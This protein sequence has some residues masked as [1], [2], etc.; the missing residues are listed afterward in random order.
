MVIVTDDSHDA[1]NLELFL[2]LNMNCSIALSRTVTQTLELLSDD[3]VKIIIA[4]VKGSKKEA[5]RLIEKLNAGS[6]FV[7][8][9]FYTACQNPQRFLE[10][11]GFPCHVIQRP[12]ARELLEI[13]RVL[14][15]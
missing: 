10:S 11:L 9:I 12:N 15:V 8:V 14:V 7:P 5:L 6:I 4:D 3:K 1:K 13:A 2:R